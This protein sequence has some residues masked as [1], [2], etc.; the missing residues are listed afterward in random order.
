MLIGAVLVLVPVVGWVLNMGHRIEMVHKMHIGQP[1]W[2]SWNNYPRLLKSGT[3][4]LL[5]MIYY[6]TP[7][8]VVAVLGLHQRQ[9][10]L[11]ALSALLLLLATVAIPGYM[12]HYCLNYDAGEIFNPVRAFGRTLQGG[13]LYWKVCYRTRRTDAITPGIV[14]TRSWF[15]GLER[16][17]LA[18]RRIQLCVSVHAAFCFV[19][20]CCQ[21]PV[22]SAFQR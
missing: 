7:G 1:A 12:T 2:P 13:G 22:E 8:A 15:S 17:V 6:Y 21:R 20:E 19:Q 9:V 3:V 5:G 4:T 10:W 11:E 14:G 18:G 16:L